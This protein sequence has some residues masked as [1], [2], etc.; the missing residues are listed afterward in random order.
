MRVDSAWEVRRPQFCAGSRLDGE[1]E[2]AA[3][4]RSDVTNDFRGSKLVLVSG[5]STLTHQRPGRNLSV[6][7]QTR[8]FWESLCSYH[9]G[10]SFYC[11]QQLGDHL[12]ALSMTTPDGIDEHVREIS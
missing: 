4:V 8:S 9:Q 5:I 10:V 7:D 3:S 2:G 1:V 12:A 6:A 11:C